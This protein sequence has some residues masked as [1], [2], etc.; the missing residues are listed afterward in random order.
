MRKP[1]D[2]GGWPTEEP[3]DQSEHPMMDWERH[4]EA[5]GRVL[6]RSR[7]VRTDVSRRGMESIPAEEYESMGYWDRRLAGMETRLIEEKFLTTEEID[8]KAA[9]L[10]RRWGKQ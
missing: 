1:N 6:P 4:L 2:R 8:R 5:L 7:F 10:E 9:E 3:I